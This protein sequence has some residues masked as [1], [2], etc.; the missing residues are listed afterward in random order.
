MAGDYGTILMTTNGGISVG[1]VD[2]IV[3]S[4]QPLKIFPNPSLDVITVESSHEW[5]PGRLSVMNV[6]GEVMIS[7]H[8]KGSQTQLD[9]GNLPCGVYFVRLTSSRS[10]EVGKFIKL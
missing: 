8:T 7:L 5:A 2:E 3:A 9:L 1:G 6:N 10:T 4:S